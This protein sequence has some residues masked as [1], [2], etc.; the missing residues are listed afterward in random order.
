M[1]IGKKLGHYVCV[2]F[3]YLFA[4]SA[5]PDHVARHPTYLARHPKYVV[6]RYPK[7]VARYRK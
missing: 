4:A 1:D 6:A 5:R 2:A 3:M 7:Y